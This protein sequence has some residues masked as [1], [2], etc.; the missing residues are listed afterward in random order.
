MRVNTPTVVNP[1]VRVIPAKVETGRDDA[2][3]DGEKKK[4]AVYARVSTFEEL[5]KIYADHG[6][7]G[8]N[9]KNRTAFNEMIEDAKE[10]QFDIIITKSISRFARN[11]LDCLTYVRM[12]KGL[13][14]PVGV[15][16]DR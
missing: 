7:T 5:Y 3:H 13:K 4:I 9:T 8:T 14:K 6:V 11:T 2:N 10:Q 16:F 12:L 1:R 15:I